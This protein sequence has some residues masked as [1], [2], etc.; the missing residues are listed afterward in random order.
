MD[1]PQDTVPGQTPE[2][3]NHPA[4]TQLV[5]V[6]GAKAERK[7]KARQMHRSV[8]FGLGMIGMVGWS[9]ATPTLAG[10]ALGIWIDR[11][12]PSRY[13]W[14]LMLLILGVMVGCASAWYW[15]ERERRK[16]EE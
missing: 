8:W 13:S 4:E 7:L 9:V 16:L 6:V 2:T 15:V 1:Q 14:T 10:L 5:A 3:L 12:F 11:R